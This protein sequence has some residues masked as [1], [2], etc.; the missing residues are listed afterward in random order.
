MSLIP[1]IVWSYYHDL[2]KMPE[3]YR[4]CIST[5]VK[6]IPP[7]WQVYLLDESTVTKYLDCNK[8]PLNF[9]KLI[10][11]RKS[12]CIRLE[13]LST[14]GGVWMDVGIILNDNLEKLIPNDPK[15]EYVGY[16]LNIFL[17]SEPHD[18]IKDAVVENWFI[19]TTPNYLITKWRDYFFEILNQHDESNIHLAYPYKDH[20]TQQQIENF[21]YKHYLLMHVLYQYLLIHDD[22]F[23][24]FHKTK[25]LLR[26]AEETALFIQSKS[27]WKSS[28]IKKYYDNY[29]TKEIKSDQ[30]LLKVRGVDFTLPKSTSVPFWLIFVIVVLLLMVTP[31]PLVVRTKSN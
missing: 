9:S 17:P 6:H 31:L 30:P 10:P 15:V 20:L 14:H 27:G 26:P 12:D 5:W 24:T 7:H 4:N 18:N 3:F 28:K 22:D 2:N 29:F 13:L 19:A 25:T 8:L 11:Q 16:Y 1:R 23:R 21:L